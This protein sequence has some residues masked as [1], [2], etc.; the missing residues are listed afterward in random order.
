MET[1]H[2]EPGSGRAASVDTRAAQGVQVGD[3]ATQTNIFQV[4]QW[5][6]QRPRQLPLAVPHFAGRSGELAALTRLLPSSA[7]LNSTVVISAIGGTAGV[8]KTAL[9]VHWAH[10]VA[11]EFPDGQ[12]YVN[13]RGFDPGGQVMEPAEAVRRFVDAL[14]VPAERIPTDL[15][16]QAALYRSELSGRRILVVLDNGVAGKVA[17]DCSR[18]EHRFSGLS[19]SG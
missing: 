2:R 4:P 13:L 6:M 3:H 18:R 11:D 9:A 8:G 5:R 17:H 1:P 12:L 10:T 15:D 14:G 7:E 16:A 19:W